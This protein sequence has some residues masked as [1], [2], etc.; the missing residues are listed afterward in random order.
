MPNGE[1]EDIKT[2]LALVIKSHL[3]EIAKQYIEHAAF[4]LLRNMEVHEAIQ[5][6]S[7]L[8]LPMNTYKTMQGITKNFGYDKHFFHLMV[9]LLLTNKT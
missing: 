3:K 6:I 2:L 5:F 9:V 7:I 4:S 1:Q 8:Y